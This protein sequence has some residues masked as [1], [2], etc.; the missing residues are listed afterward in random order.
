MV[1]P[2]GDSLTLSTLPEPLEVLVRPDHAVRRA[3][4]RPAVA[5]VAGVAVVCVALAVLEAWTFQVPRLERS[6]ESLTA[7]NPLTATC[8]L[9]TALSLF[10]AAESLPTSASRWS[11]ICA[12]A[13]IAAALIASSR[14]YSPW[15]SL[16]DLA[17]FGDKIAADPAG[18]VRMS[19]ASALNLV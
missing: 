17:L 19:P 2:P 6:V 12:G 18:P 3:W 10:L 13:V 16:L 9:L 5:T 1:S 15:D 4:T 7:M 11:R 14:F 8:L